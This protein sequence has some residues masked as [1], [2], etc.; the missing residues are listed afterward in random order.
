MQVLDLLT[1]DTRVCAIDALGY[2]FSSS[3]IKPSSPELHY[4]FFEEAMKAMGETGP[5]W[6][7]GHSAGGEQC[8]RMAARKKMVPRIITPALFSLLCSKSPV[9]S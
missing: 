9:L 2:G 6:C 4:T 7:V 3:S 1:K 8:V 5:F